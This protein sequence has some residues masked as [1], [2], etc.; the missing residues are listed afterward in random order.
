MITGKYLW[1][2]D[3]LKDAYDIRR[4]V[5]ID[6][7]GREEINVFDNFDKISVHGIIYNEEKKAVA[8]GRIFYDGE[9]YR[10]EKIAVLIEERNKG[11]GEFLVKML[12]DK[13]FE[14]GASDINVRTQE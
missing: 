8:S 6:E 5:F 3:D 9:I 14:A 2:G 13:G 10:I 1:N 4:R 12:I 7:L 11:Y